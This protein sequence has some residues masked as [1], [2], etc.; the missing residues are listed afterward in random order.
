MDNHTFFQTKLKAVLMHFHRQNSFAIVA[1]TG[2]LLSLHPIS[3]IAIFYCVSFFK[4][5][6]LI[7][8]SCSFSASGVSDSASSSWQTW[9][10]KFG[11]HC[12]QSI[13]IRILLASLFISDCLDEVLM[14]QF[15]K[16]LIWYTL[17]LSKKLIINHFS[18]S[19]MLTRVS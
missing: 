19:Y 14:I 12:F 2:K 8:S 17:F 1:F 5:L 13:D 11:Y 6:F 18:L 3:L 9:I 10:E 7:L 15:S 16:M 4:K